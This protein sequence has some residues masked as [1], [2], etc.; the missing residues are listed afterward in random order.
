MRVKSL[1]LAVAGLCLRALFLAV[2]VCVWLLALTS[3]VCSDWRTA[4]T[5]L[6]GIAVGLLGWWWGWGAISVA[7]GWAV[8]VAPAACWLLTRPPTPLGEERAREVGDWL[9]ERLTVE[10]AERRHATELRGWRGRRV[11][12]FG[13]CNAQWRRLRARMVAG[14]EVWAYEF[15]GGSLCAEG[16]VAL[17][18]GG[19]VVDL[20]LVWES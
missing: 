2:V 7:V 13:Y 12:P 1:L 19:R 6:P 14:D 17:V 9:R 5:A 10:E 15:W 20:V 16:G 3:R 4:L 11:V 18:R 8:A